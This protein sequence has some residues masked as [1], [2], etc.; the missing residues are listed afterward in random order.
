MITR[1]SMLQYGTTATFAFGTTP[2]FARNDSLA[3]LRL[4]PSRFIAGLA[5]DI[6][7]AVVV[8]LVSDAIVGHF[9]STGRVRSVRLGSSSSGSW[10]ADRYRVSLAVIK[11]ASL[12]TSRRDQ[13]ALEI[14][15]ATEEQTKRMKIARDYLVAEK[16]DVAFWAS[17]QQASRRVEPDEPYDN[18][19]SIEWFGSSTIDQERHYAQLIRETGVNAFREIGLV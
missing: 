11:A 1:R 12:R 3:L 4:H 8:D 13:I 7:R 17:P 14:N 9:R 10:H 5:F 16:L 2:G 6:G 15:H 19:F 18:L